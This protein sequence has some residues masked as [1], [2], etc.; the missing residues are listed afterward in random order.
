MNDGT[1]MYDTG[2]RPQYTHIGSIGNPAAD[3]IRDKIGKAADWK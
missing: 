3:M 1:F 2:R